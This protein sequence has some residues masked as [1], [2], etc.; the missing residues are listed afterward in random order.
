MTKTWELIVEEDPEN[1]E[2]C[3]LQFPEDFIEQVGWK[4]GD[5]LLWDL[6]EDG[7]VVLSKVE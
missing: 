1:P 5:T 3:I 7:S 2:E 6:Q 4:E